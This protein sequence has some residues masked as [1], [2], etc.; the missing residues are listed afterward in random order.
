MAIADAVLT[1]YV[2][3]GTLPQD[4]RSYVDRGADSELYQALRAGE[5]CYVLTSRQMGKSSLMVR[6]AARLRGDGVTAVLLDLTAVGQNLSAAQWYDGLLHLLSLSLGLENEIEEYWLGKERFGPVQRWMEALREVVLKRVTGQIVLFID[7]IDAVRSLPFSADEFFAAIRECGNRR[8]EDAEYRRLTFCLLGVA[9][10]S[11]LV[12]DTR[13]TPFNIGRRIELADFTGP[14][15]GVLTAGLPAHGAEVAGAACPALNL[16][17]RVLYWTS[18]HPYLTQRLCRAVGGDVSTSHAGTVDRLCESLFFR[19]DSREADDNLQFVRERMLRSGED[20][21]GL[22]RLYERM[23]SGRRVENDETN[24]L[25]GVLKLSGIAR[26]IGSP[27]TRDNGRLII[28]NRIYERAFDRRW[29][30]ANMPGAEV[31]RQRAAYRLGAL[32]TAAAAGVVVAILASV[33]LFTIALARRT[34]RFLYAADMNVVQ[35][36]LEDS[37]LARARQL[38]ELHRPGAFWQEDLRGFEWR[39]FWQLARDQ[40]QTTL[41]GHKNGVTAVAWSLDGSLIASGDLD[42]AVRLWKVRGGTPQLSDVLQGVTGPISSLAFSPDGACL[43]ASYGDRNDSMPGDVTLWDL[44]SRP[45]SG[46]KHSPLQLHAHLKAVS[47]LAFAD[48]GRLLAT[49]SQDGTVRLWQMHSLKAHQGSW[50]LPKMVAE[51]HHN[52]HGRPV[53]A[54]AVSPDGHMLA[55]GDADNTIKLWSIAVA[56]PHRVSQ[57][58]TLLGHTSF[59]ESLAFSPRGGVLASAGKDR[60]L[61]IWSLATGRQI[62]ALPGHQNEIRFIAFSPNG[63]M[64]AT[65]SDDSTVRIWEAAPPN[66]R[67]PFWQVGYTQGPRQVAVLRGHEGQVYSVAY[68]S[69]G[70][71]IASGSMDGTVR[72]WDASARDSANLLGD[73]PL[74]SPGGYRYVSPNLGFSPDGRRLTTAGGGHPFSIDRP[75]DVRVWDVASRREAVR[76][77]GGRDASRCATF[78]PGGELLA[79]GSQWE[80]TV[81]LWRLTDGR[82][83]AV[84]AGHSGRVCAAAFAPTVQDGRSDGGQ[85]SCCLATG[86]FDNTVRLWKVV[87]PSGRSAPIAELRGHTGH[88]MSLAFSPTG[89]LIASGSIDGTVRLWSVR[90]RTQ[91]AVLRGHRQPIWSV[92]FS[93]DGRT[94]ASGSLDGDVRLWQVGQGSDQVPSI[95]RGHQAAVY[96]VAFSKDGKTLASGSS[97][98]TVKLW[99]LATEREVATL[100]GH[101][102]FVYSVAFSPDG[103]TLATASSDATVRLWQA[104]PE[105]KRQ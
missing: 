47:R 1:F 8:A 6:T 19:A 82:E 79:T 31:R 18:G 23:L 9:R 74:S 37:K 87:L 81:R 29:V 84:L 28:R 4:A 41:G 93:P 54:L 48:S 80:N 45:G 67:L 2:T 68:S 20:I 66:T 14:E 24:P 94:V 50:D 22:L 40:S 46:R 71:L 85:R 12:R 75:H 32:R 83:M 58:G 78:S 69:D 13:T 65:G 76:L 38:L 103:D 27:T 35:Q 70:R 77:R 42:G 56:D 91:I 26:V 52:P 25:V 72:L 89:E 102:D 73:G 30:A 44:S 59:V 88:I 7:E 95:L 15:A 57:V 90:K 21:V 36:A 5:F 62:A 105:E 104:A 100:R 92:A 61:R 17:N 64:V 63:R 97:D 43:A 11:D 16:L 101:Q 96:S 34:E 10:P 53:L 49:A 3:G 98:Y 55:S 86:G 39:F 99:N 51:L 60:V 33:L